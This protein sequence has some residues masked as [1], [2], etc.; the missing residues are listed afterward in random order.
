MSKFSFSVKMYS[1]QLANKKE[2]EGRRKEVRKEVRKGE[3]KRQAE[4]I[5]YSHS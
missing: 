5:H 4:V 2:R 1:Q 3:K